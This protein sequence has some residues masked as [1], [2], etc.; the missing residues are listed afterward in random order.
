MLK[1]LELLTTPRIE[2]AEYLNEYLKHYPE[3]ILPHKSDHVRH[4]YYNYAIKVDTL[5]LGVPREILVRALVAEGIPIICGY[6]PPIYHEPLFQT[7]VVF[8]NKGF[9][10]T[11]KTY[12]DVDRD[13]P[14]GLCPNVEKIESHELIYTNLCRAGVT[15]DDLQQIVNSFDKVLSNKAQLKN[16]QE[17]NA[18]CCGKQRCGRSSRVTG[19][20]AKESSI[21]DM[22]E[23]LSQ[24]I[25]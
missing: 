5:K 10:Y 23:I 7:K 2:A 3:L 13:Y 8:G 18:F 9:P 11:C 22:Q 21:H 25:I 20:L 15:Q 4:V 1:K 24:K 17:S 16:I 12:G 6:V 14:I 19:E